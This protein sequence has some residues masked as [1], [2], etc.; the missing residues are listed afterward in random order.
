MEC[1]TLFFVLWATITLVERYLCEKSWLSA[2]F[3]GGVVTLLT[4]FLG[5]GLPHWLSAPASNHP[6]P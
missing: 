5:I 6:P 1:A 3:V 2:I 4:P